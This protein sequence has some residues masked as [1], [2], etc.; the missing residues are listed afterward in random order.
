[1]K[2]FMYLSISILCLSVSLLIGFHFGNKNAGAGY[3]DPTPAGNVIS[4]SDDGLH[5]YVLNTSGEIWLLSRAVAGW[6]GPF[7]RT[8]PLPVPISDVAYWGGQGNAVITKSDVGYFWDGAS[9]SWISAGPIPGTTTGVPTNIEPTTWG[10][11]KEKY[12]K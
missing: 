1:M 5:L 9:G 3:V 10:Q 4:A 11:L 6:S 12:D 8:P 7:I 2:R